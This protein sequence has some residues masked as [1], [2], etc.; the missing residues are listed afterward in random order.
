M[1]GILPQGTAAQNHTITG[2]ATVYDAYGCGVVTNNV[3]VRVY[4]A[5]SGKVGPNGGEVEGYV[6]YNAQELTDVTTAKC[7]VAIAAGDPE[8]CAQVQWVEVEVEVEV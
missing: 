3:P 4:P 2:T 7:D 1:T 8:F 5:T 6:P